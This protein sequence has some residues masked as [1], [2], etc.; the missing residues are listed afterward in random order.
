MHLAATS[1]EHVPGWD[2]EDHH[3]LAALLESQR[4]LG[5]GL[6]GGDARAVLEQ[7][8]QAFAVCDA[9]GEASSGHLT[10]YF[11]PVLRGSRTPSDVY[12]YPV[13]ALPDE[14]A[15]PAAARSTT[16]FTRRE[17]EAGAL[18][19]CG[20]E[21]CW[22]SDAVDC[23]F[24]HVQ[25]S[26]RICFDDDTMVDCAFAGKNGHA[27]TSIG[28]HLVAAGEIAGEEISLETLRAWLSRQPAVAREVM[29][30]N[31][32]Y[33][34]FALHEID[35]RREATRTGPPGAGG[36]PLIPDRSLA[37]DPDF[38]PLGR[39]MFVVSEPLGLARGLLA[40]DIGSAIRGAA[41]GDIYCGTGDAAGA[42]AGSINHPASFFVLLPRELP[43]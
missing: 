6:N 19:G 35:A 18:D 3:A 25:G 34:F 4:V 15:D 27:Y 21:L 20:L 31:D 23:F 10:G 11:E 17:I 12:R 30:L 14:L 13:Y 33:I 5:T 32:S 29:Q 42:R 8:F 38:H 16:F 1:F 2:R 43:R 9:D 7:R 36:V 26:G 28:K 41:R 37:V 24:L 40:H 22:L 39:V